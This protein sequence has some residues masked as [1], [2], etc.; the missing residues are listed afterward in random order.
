[1]KNKSNDT[2]T[3]RIMQSNMGVHKKFTSGPDAMLY[4]VKSQLHPLQHISLYNRLA[5][6]K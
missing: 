5:V 6:S 4:L 1:M 2:K 3:D